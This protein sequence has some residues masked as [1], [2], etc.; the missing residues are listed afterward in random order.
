[1]IKKKEEVKSFRKIPEAWQQAATEPWQI[2]E[3]GTSRCSREEHIGA[4]TEGLVQGNFQS[5]R[6]KGAQAEI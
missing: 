5:H 6:R 4:I 2:T 1:M 3:E